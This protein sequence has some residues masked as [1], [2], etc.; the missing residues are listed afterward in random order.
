MV[1][2][3]IRTNRLIV[4]AYMNL[5]C[6]SLIKLQGF[7]FLGKFFV[8]TQ[9]VFGNRS[10]PAIYD[11]LHEVFLFVAQLRS[12]VDKYYL[13]CTLV[14]FVAVT[15]DKCTNEGIVLCLHLEATGCHTGY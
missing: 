9:L 3:D 11:R 15:L 13:L 6:S 12:Q 10:F 14:N 7:H 4:H 8:K 5:V 2:P 1:T